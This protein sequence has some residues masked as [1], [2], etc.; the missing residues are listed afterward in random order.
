MHRD[1]P[2]TW[3]RVF[4]G[5]MFPATRSARGPRRAEVIESVT[6][7]RYGR[8]STP[9]TCP[10]MVIAAAGDLDHKRPAAAIETRFAA[11]K[12]GRPRSAAHRL[13]RPSRS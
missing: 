7:R 2:R 1:E 5:A 3:S 9:T 8:S 4:A 10:N 11:G 6:C 13:G 12:A